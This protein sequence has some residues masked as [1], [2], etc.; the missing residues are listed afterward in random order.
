MANEIKIDKLLLRR[1]LFADKEINGIEYT[2]PDGNH[3]MFIYKGDQTILTWALIETE[4]AKL[5]FRITDEE[6]NIHQLTGIGDFSIDGGQNLKHLIIPDGVLCIEKG[7]FASC[8]SLLSVVF[9]ASLQRLESVFWNCP[10][11][12]DNAGGVIYYTG[13]QQ[14]WRTLIDSYPGR[15]MMDCTP[16]DEVV[17]FASD[18]A[19]SPEFA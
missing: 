6:G 7:A 3:F 17:R 9:P 8:R 18:G 19:P 15:G 4:T 13:T 16:Y 14:E 2:D 1:N 5:P 10:T 11:F 12:E